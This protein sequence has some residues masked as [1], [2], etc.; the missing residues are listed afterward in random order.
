[1]KHAPASWG[2]VL[3]G[4][5]FSLPP[6]YWEVT[7]HQLFHDKIAN[8]MM[9]TG[10]E[11]QSRLAVLRNLCQVVFPSCLRDFKDFWAPPKKDFFFHKLRSP[12]FC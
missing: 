3:H 12:L 6:S 1:L 9:G 5:P 11:T 4:Q 8:L 2:S 7:V 10:H